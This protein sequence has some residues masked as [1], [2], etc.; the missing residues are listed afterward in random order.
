MV[1]ATTL[2]M[3][4]T[5]FASWLG[6]AASGMLAP[7]PVIAWPLV[8]FAQVQAGRPGMV[9]MVRGNAIGAVGVIAFYLVVAGLLE[10]LG[11]AATFSLAVALAVVVTVSL[12][13]VLRSH[14]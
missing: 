9:P 3:V 2:L 14:G 5:G 7:I 11:I 12:A 6:P 10:T 8:V 4:T 1:A 13:A